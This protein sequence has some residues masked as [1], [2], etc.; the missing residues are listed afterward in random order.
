MITFHLKPMFAV[1]QL[2]SNAWNNMH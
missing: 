1:H 2:V